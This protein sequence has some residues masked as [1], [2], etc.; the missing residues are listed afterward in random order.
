MLK[1]SIYVYRLEI[2]SLISQTCHFGSVGREKSLTHIIN[3]FFCFLVLHVPRLTLTARVLAG[4]T[5]AVCVRCGVGIPT[6]WTRGQSPQRA[7]VRT[8]AAMYV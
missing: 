8:I 7:R 1:Q 2:T 4:A 3:P 6:G 5:D